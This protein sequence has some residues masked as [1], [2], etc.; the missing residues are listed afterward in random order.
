MCKA[1][2]PGNMPFHHVFANYGYCLESCSSSFKVA[3]ARELAKADY[4]KW[5]HFVAAPG[6]Q[7]QILDNSSQ[8]SLSSSNVFLPH[9]DAE[10]RVAAVGESGEIIELNMQAGTALVKLNSSGTA[11]E[12]PFEVLVP[13]A[14]EDDQGTTLLPTPGNATLFSSWDRNT[15]VAPTHGQCW[16]KCRE[17]DGGSVWG[18]MHAGS[19]YLATL[20]RPLWCYARSRYVNAAT[21]D[22]SPIGSLCLSDDDC[23]SV[24]EGSDWLCSDECG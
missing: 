11:L 6:R 17:Q 22:A 20:G 2:R 7:V 4:K 21:A 16:S 5:L 23:G 10:A 14:V 9:D 8:I 12:F 24:E 18:N 3:L 19:K 13:Y 1:R 15:I